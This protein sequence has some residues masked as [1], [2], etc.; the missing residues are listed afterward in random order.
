M[1]KRPTTTPALEHE[2]DLLRESLVQ[3]LTA[4]RDLEQEIEDMRQDAAVHRRQKADSHMLRA[5]NELLEAQLDIREDRRIR[6]ESVLG[7][8]LLDDAARVR[9]QAAEI[10]ALRE[11]LDRIRNSRSWRLTAALRASRGKMI[12]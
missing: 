3:T 8:A 9:A 10:A 1:S 5:M 12:G 11:E 6:R 7:R 4:L 2:R